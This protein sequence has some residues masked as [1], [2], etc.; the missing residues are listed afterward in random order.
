MAKGRSLQDVGTPPLCMSATVWISQDGGSGVVAGR[1]PSIQAALG[2]PRSCQDG[3]RRAL[4]L[5]LFK[6]TT[7]QDAALCC[8]RFGRKAY[9]WGRSLRDARIRCTHIF[10]SGGS[11]FQLDRA[12]LKAQVVSFV[13]VGLGSQ[14]PARERVSVSSAGGEERELGPGPIVPSISDKN[15]T[16]SFCV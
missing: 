13:T 5:A 7:R 16:V 4:A 1:H 6:S 9:S 8:V 10:L 14:P 12:T 15:P 3:G 11:W 2:R